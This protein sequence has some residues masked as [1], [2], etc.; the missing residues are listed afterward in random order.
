MHKLARKAAN[1]LSPHQ[2]GVGVPGGAEAIIHTV[3]QVMEEKE[4][5]FLMQLDLV[6]AYNQV[7]RDHAFREVE[8]HF[9]EM[10]NWVMTC[11]KNQAKLIFGNTVILSWAGFHQGDPLASLLF[12]LGAHPVIKRIAQV[13]PAG[14]CVVP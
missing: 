2:L 13:A 5:A 1:F 8:E 6:N 11:Y 7:D 3:R 9:P 4:D 10:L 14:E 12:S